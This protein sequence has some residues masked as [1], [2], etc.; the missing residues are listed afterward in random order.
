MNR[1]CD[2]SKLRTAQGEHLDFGNIFRLRMAWNIS[3]E[4]LERVADPRLLSGLTKALLAWKSNFDL[5]TNDALMVLAVYGYRQL[6]GETQSVNIF[7]YN[8]WWLT[9]ETK[10]LAATRESG[11]AARRELHDAARLPTQLHGAGPFDGGGER[12]F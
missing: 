1:F 6:H 4:D 12:D 11:P 3:A 9:N 8:T 7:G 10:I 5:A 2:Y